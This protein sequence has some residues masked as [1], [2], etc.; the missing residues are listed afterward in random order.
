MAEARHR[1]FLRHFLRVE[2]VLKAYLLAAAGDPH[3]ADDLLQ[4]VS[5]V[6]WEKFDQ[7]DTAKPFRNWALGVARLESLKQ[8]QR[9]AR[10]REVLSPST[11]DA[12]AGT[13]AELAGE[14]DDRAEHLRGCVKQ[15]SEKT[16]Q[17]LRL[18]YWD[19]LPFR[20]IAEKLGRS[21][22]SLEMLLVRARRQLR[23]CVERKL[24]HGEGGRL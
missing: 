16:R 8:R 9:L 23:Q 6:L 4:E 18:R 21:V 24:A 1:V 20:Q 15:L 22:A 17:V 10:S 5:S 7:Y 12:L 13:T 11:I 19:T 3:V 2:G 14:L